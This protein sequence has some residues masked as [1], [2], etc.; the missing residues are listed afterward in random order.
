METRQ[1]SPGAKADRKAGGT[2]PAPKRCRLQ[3]PR[4]GSGGLVA[5]VFFLPTGET[6]SWVNLPGETEQD[7]TTLGS[8]SKVFIYINAYLLILH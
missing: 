5:L 7:V 1:G 3:E 8:I 6:P 4:Q 2:R